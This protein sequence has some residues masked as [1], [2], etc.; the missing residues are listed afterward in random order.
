[1]P[2]SKVWEICEPFR[3]LPLTKNQ[4]IRNG[5]VDVLATVAV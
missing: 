5:F 1:M 3:A 2:V 4:Q